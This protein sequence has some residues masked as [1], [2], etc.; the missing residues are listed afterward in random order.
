ME[1]KE[2]RAQSDDAWAGSMMQPVESGGGENDNSSFSHIIGSKEQTIE[3]LNNQLIKKEGQIIAIEQSIVMK[4]QLMNTF[5]A[6]I[7]DLSTQINAATDHQ[8]RTLLQQQMK[9]LR[10]DRNDL[11][12]DIERQEKQIQR[13]EKQM[14]DLRDDRNALRNDIERLR[15]QLAP[16]SESELSAASKLI[17]ASRQNLLMR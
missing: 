1:S 17:R 2:V 16:G 4:D 15:S 6:K 13:Q 7:L 12:N 9:D 8:E 10:N 5:M 14:K 3:R 11:R